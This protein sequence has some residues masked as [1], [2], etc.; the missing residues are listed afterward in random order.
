MQADV[1]R[2]PVG[3]GAMHVERFGHG[4]TAVILI[5]GFATSSFLWRHVAPAI[6]EAGHTA[7]ALDLLGHGESDRP[8]DADF[9][10]AA[11]AEYLDAAMTVLRVARGIIVGVDIGGDIALRLAAKRPERVEKLVLINTPAFE[12]L[13]SKDITQMQRSTAKFAFR[14]TRG[15]LGAA[16]LVEQVLKG[17]V[18]DPDSHMP[19]KLIAQYLA[20][21]VG[22]DGVNH[23]LTLASSISADDMEDVDLS[24]IHVPTLVLWGEQD[25][26]V[27]Q[28][29]ADKLINV[30]P[31]GR[32]VRMPGVGRLLPE[33]NPDQLNQLLLEFMRRRAAA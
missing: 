12:E 15:I 3:P 23:L 7:Y 21:F 24:S 28:K 17:S 10:I 1:L 11:Q 19:V 30:L 13:P 16:P 4:G 9:G 25:G 20:P 14:T 22:K 5:H 18:A 33:E 26:W 29:V 32:L 8:S 31:D 2:V 6:T 27:D